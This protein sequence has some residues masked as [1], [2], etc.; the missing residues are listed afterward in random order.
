V[1]VWLVR[2]GVTAHNQDGIWQ[3]QRDVPLAPEGRAQARRLAERLARLGLTWTALYTSDLSRAA[4]TA[5]IVGARL[6]LEPRSDR[7]LR[8]V[9]VGELSGL[10][11][12]E[13]QA[14][15]GDYVQRSQQDPWRTRFPGGETLAELYERV[16]AF[17]RELGEGRHLV[18]SHGGAIRAAV[19]GVLE[20]RAAVPWRLRLENTSITRLH[21]PEGASGGGFVHTVGDA[22]HLEAGWDLDG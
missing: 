19:L 1:E 7:R 13:V 14:R 15:F 2:H 12:P 4:E 5:R 16:W 8:E 18:V 11:R 21:F 3:G 6:G 17:L 9:C 22:A 20:S 10:T